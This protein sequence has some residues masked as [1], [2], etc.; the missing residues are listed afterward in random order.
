MTTAKKIIG[1]VVQ[2]SSIDG[3]IAAGKP[4]SVTF[5]PSSLEAIRYFME[6]PHHSKA[7]SGM[8]SVLAEVFPQA[9]DESEVDTGEDDHPDIIGRIPDDRSNMGN[10]GP[11][12][13]SNTRP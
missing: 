5:G 13:W 9:D 1:K 7:I 4:V 11:N 10:Q 3:L 2:E 6:K 8:Q 12:E